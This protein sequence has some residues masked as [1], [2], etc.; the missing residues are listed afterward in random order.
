MDAHK[1][2]ATK[3][4]FHLRNES[5]GMSMSYA[6]FSFSFPI[7]SIS[8]QGVARSSVWVCQRWGHP[9]KIQ[10]LWI[11]A[12]LQ[13]MKRKKCAKCIGTLPHPLRSALITRPI[14]TCCTLG[15]LFICLSFGRSVCQSASVGLWVAQLQVIASAI[16]KTNWYC[17][18]LHTSNANAPAEPQNACPQRPNWIKYLL[19]HLR[20]IFIPFYRSNLPAT[21]FALISFRRWGNLC[22]SMS[23]PR[24]RHRPRPRTRLGSCA[25]RAPGSRIPRRF[26]YMQQAN[27]H[28]RLR[29]LAPTPA[30]SPYPVL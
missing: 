26:N 16:H 5:I 7:W 6:R 18:L 22:H 23:T 9:D 21:C 25:F 29:P 13:E 11:Y 8:G 12:P 24:P 2:Y 30:S 28:C 17:L 14:H 3:I 27:G 10:S 20:A 1:K 19:S 4:I 15:L